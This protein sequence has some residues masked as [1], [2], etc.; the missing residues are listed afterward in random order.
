MSTIM[1]SQR[2]RR[3]TRHRIGRTARAGEKGDAVTLLTRRDHD[4]FRRVLRDPE[5]LVHQ[6]EIPRFR[7]IPFD[8]E[9]SFSGRSFSRNG[10]PRKP[11]R[12]SRSHTMRARPPGEG[13]KQACL[14][15]I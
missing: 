12:D 15:L 2:R 10:P 1:T 6:A 7:R 14:A 9:R 13:A 3:N 4:N 11:R 8:S 5:I